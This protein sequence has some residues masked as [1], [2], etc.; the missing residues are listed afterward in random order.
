M[1]KKDDE[2]PLLFIQDL[3]RTSNLQYDRTESFW[4]WIDTYMYRIPD[5]TMQNQTGNPANNH[6]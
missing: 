4:K 6:Y 3:S 1:S 5:V 2:Q